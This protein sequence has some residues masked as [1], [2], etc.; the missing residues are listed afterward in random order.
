VTYN[1]S[2]NFSLTASAVNLTNTK[3]GTYQGEPSLP[4]D[5]QVNDRMY[6]LK[7]QLSF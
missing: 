7:A 2:K 3:R 4:R 6:T 5:V 1:F